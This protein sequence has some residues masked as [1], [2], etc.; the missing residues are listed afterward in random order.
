MFEKRKIKFISKLVEILKI[1]RLILVFLNLNFINLNSFF[2]S[3]YISLI[4]KS[5]LSE[6]FIY[7]I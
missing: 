7:Y 2:F 4:I 1:I 6:S 3:Y 5:L